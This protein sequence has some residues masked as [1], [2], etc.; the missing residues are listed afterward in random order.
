MLYASCKDIMLGSIL[1]A[2]Y[3]YLQI[4]HLVIYVSYC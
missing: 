2:L 4:G 3:L 1:L